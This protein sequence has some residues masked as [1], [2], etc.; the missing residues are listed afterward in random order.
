MHIGN[1]AAAAAVTT[2]LFLAATLALAG[3]GVEPAQTTATGPSVTSNPATSGVVTTVSAAPVTP[4]APQYDAT[5]IDVDA[6]VMTTSAVYAANCQKSMGAALELGNAVV[7]YLRGMGDLASLQ[8]LVAPS[9][10]EGLSEMLSL[11]GEPSGCKVTTTSASG[12]YTV[13]EVGLLFADG[14]SLHPGFS[15][16]VLVDED[17]T[18]ITAI[19]PDASIGPPPGVDLPGDAPDLRYLS[20][21]HSFYTAEAV[22]LGTVVEEFP[23][24]EYEMVVYKG[25]VLQVEKAYGSPA[26]PACITIYAL[27]N[28]TVEIDGVPQEVRQELPLD[29]KPGDRLLV[30]LMKVAYYSTPYLQAHE[31]WVQANWAV[32]A[33]SDDGACTRVTGQE[34]DPESGHEFPLA[35]L[36]GIIL[37][38]DKEPSRIE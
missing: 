23:L 27:G 36:E 10:Q 30:P 32:F 15:V 5:T 8:G 2:A 34:L 22:V 38:Q 26:I 6:V 35:E 24:R 7:A 20:P 19:A 25:Y 4:T 21:F 3:C 11:L 28:G 16:T 33:V 1:R 31:Y 17:Q 29:A 14:K 12:S 9:A 18:S 37:E 13:V